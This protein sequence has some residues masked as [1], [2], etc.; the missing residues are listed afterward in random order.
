MVATAAFPA[1]HIAVYGDWPDLEWLLIRSPLF[2]L[3][4]QLFILVI[5]QIRVGLFHCCHRRFFLWLVL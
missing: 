4:F 2:G 1:V 3:L 5:N